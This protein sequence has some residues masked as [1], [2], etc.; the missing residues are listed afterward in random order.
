MMLDYLNFTDAV[1][2]IDYAVSQVYAD[3]QVLTVD[4]G[5]SASSSAFCA[6][7]REK[8]GNVR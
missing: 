1:A 4:Q 8:L 2:R 6:A 7:V 3:G 5:G